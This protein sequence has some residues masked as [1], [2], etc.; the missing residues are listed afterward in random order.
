MDSDIDAVFR[1]PPVDGIDSLPKT[2][3][4]YAMLNRVTRMVNIGQAENIRRRC[5][6]HRSQL[7]AGTAPNLRMRRDA[8]RH[9]ADAFLYITLELL[10]I[11]AQ[12]NVKRELNKLEL[13]WVVQF[14]AHVEQFG[15]VSEAGHCRTR[16][17]R[18]RDREGKLMRPNSQKYELLPGVD[19]CDPIHPGLLESWVPGS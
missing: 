15:Y 12:T 17:S 3:G 9:G 6:M 13:W 7:R 14:Q 2:H 5:A 16:G 4:I 19:I 10:E 1:T 18:L 8:L 11:G